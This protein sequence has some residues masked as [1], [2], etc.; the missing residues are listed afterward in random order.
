[1]LTI[2]HS[3]VNGTSMDFLASLGVDELAGVSVTV[4]IGG[5]DVLIISDHAMAVAA[6]PAFA[7]YPSLVASDGRV[8]HAPPSWEAC[9]AFESI[10]PEAAQNLATGGY[11]PKKDFADRFLPVERQAILAAIRAGDVVLEDA[12]NYLNN[13][14]KDPPGVNLRDPLLLTWGKYLV[15]VVPPGRTTPILTQDR[16]DAI[17]A[18]APEA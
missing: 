14:V 9:L 6:C 16:A 12:N 8:L 7:G 1:M 13:F 3:P 17:L 10:S 11:I 5:Q 2:L 15:E 4:N 18:L